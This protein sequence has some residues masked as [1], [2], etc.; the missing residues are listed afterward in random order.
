VKSE[1]EV[2]EIIAGLKKEYYDATHNCYAY[3]IGHIGTPAIR[4]N[5]DGE[6][7]GTAG[8][9]IYG[10]IISSDLKNILIVVIRYFGGTKLGVSGLINAYRETANITIKNAD[11]IENAIR[12]VYTVEFDYSLMNPVMQVLK[13]NAVIIR[14]NGYY[15]NKALISFEVVRSHTEEII[16]QLDKIYGLV[17]KFITIV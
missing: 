5:D 2:K 3:Y 8:R 16:S 6:P 17:Q 10:Q 7:S 11:I 15:N 12:N 14:E 4:M 9:P 13:N 1:N